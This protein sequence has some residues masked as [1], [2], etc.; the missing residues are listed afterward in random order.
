M[1][2]WW[3]QEKLNLPRQRATDM[4]AVRRG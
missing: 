4:D 2:T 1:L 3:Y